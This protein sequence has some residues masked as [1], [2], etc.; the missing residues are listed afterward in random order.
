MKH[1]I[2]KW[3]VKFS[4]HVYKTPNLPKNLAFAMAANTSFSSPFFEN[5]PITS[6]SAFFSLEP[7]SKQLI[8]DV[9]ISDITDTRLLHDWLRSQ[10]D[11]NGRVEKGYCLVSGH[12]AA[13]A[14]KLT[15]YS[16]ALLDPILAKDR[17]SFEYQWVINL[18]LS[19]QILPISSD[20]YPLL[21]P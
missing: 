11:Y 2:P 10:I 3:M 19:H 7:L 12:L 21:H 16:L 14:E 17:R 5:I 18:L 1:G 4:D 6:R 13:T 8:V 9:A 15:A 20:G